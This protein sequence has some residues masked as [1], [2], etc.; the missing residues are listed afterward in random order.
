MS[1]STIAR[2]TPR[3]RH[4][5][6]AFAIACIAIGAVFRI[7]LAIRCGVGYDEVLVMAT[8][9]EELSGSVRAFLID[10]PVRRSNAITPL[11]WWLQAAAA[12]PLGPG[13]LLSLRLAPVILGVATLVLIA[14]KAPRR[15]GRRSAA[16]LLL[17]VSTSDV[18][19]LCNA[20]GEFAE[21]LLMLLL[22]PAL[23]GVG[24]PR[25]PVRKGLLWLVMLMTHLGKGLFLVGGLAAAELIHLTLQRP[26]A[27]STRSFGCSL[28]VA[29]LPTAA[30]LWLVN[31]L[32]F[33]AGPVKTDAG[34]ATDI[35]HALTRIT[36]DYQTTKTHMVVDPFA[37]MQVYLDGMVWPATVLWAVPLLA[38]AAA[39][40]MPVFRGARQSRRS[41]FAAGLVPWIAVGAGLVIGGGMVGAR[42]HL[43]YWPVLWVMAS[44]GLQRI[45]RRR[46][47]IVVAAIAWS[48]HV[49]LAFSWRSW[50]DHTLGVSVTGMALGAVVLAAAILQAV[51]IP[52][53]R[54]SANR[55]SCQVAGAAL[56]AIVAA[57]SLL[58]YGPVAWGPAARF[59]PMCT[60]QPTAEMLL[61]AS[62]DAYRGQGRPWPGPHGRTLRVDLANFHLFCENRQPL[63]VERAIAY[64]RQELRH[65]PDDPRAWFYLGLGYQEA[66]A[67]VDWVRQAWQRSYALEPTPMVAERLS[68]LPPE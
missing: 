2:I 21:S 29:F 15:L 7:A 63:D 14:W 20:R 68:A 60:A 58:C 26:Q 39:S 65:R 25:K 3:H 52:Q 18:M 8:G 33:A 37:A 38:G 34:T 57:A 53:F 6:L 27:R 9:L 49:T 61:L 35:W 62:I 59:E 17:I 16:V 67:P 47:A 13:S 1:P 50:I 43:L 22:W 51:T 46:G 30:W 5:Y 56:L 40:V 64:L 31:A 55:F 19:A 54:L 10:V 45:W 24:D 4:G 42:F 41:V 12:A 32:A 23:L 36:T 28:A 11:W 44:M 66:G 48:L